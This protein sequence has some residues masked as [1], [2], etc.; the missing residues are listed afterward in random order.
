[1]EYPLFCAFYSK[2]C[3]VSICN[4][5][6]IQEIFGSGGIVYS[7]FMCFQQFKASSQGVVHARQ[8]ASFSRCADRPPTLLDV[9]EMAIAWCFVRLRFD[10]NIVP[11]APLDALRE[12]VVFSRPG[13]NIHIA[14]F[15]LPLSH[16]VG[17]SGF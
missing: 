14:G 5:K 7:A 6:V 2:Q 16:P 10:K 3:F 8:V 17:D 9:R 13:K 12:N 4:E 1:V 15:S 11:F